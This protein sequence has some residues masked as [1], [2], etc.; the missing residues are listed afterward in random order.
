MI[1][2]RAYLISIVAIFL[3]LGIGV[4]AGATFIDQLTVDALNQ[5]IDRVEKNLIEREEEQRRLEARIEE[6]DAFTAEA[7]NQLVTDVLVGVPVIV[8]AERGV[9]SATVDSTVEL[10]EAAGASVGGVL[11][12]EEGVLF[13]DPALREEVADAL[14]STSDDPGEL[15]ASTF[16]AIGRSLTNGDEVSLSSDGTPTTLAPESTTTATGA[17]GQVLT[18]LLDSGVVSWEP[19][20]EGQSLAEV[21]DPSMRV[22]VVAGSESPLGPSVTIQL[23]RS[24]TGSG[25][26]VVVAEVTPTDGERGVVVGPIRN[27]DDLTSQVSTVDDLELASGRVAA[28]LAVAGLGQGTVGHYGFAD[29]ATSV[30]PPPQPS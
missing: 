11:W 28:V 19:S 22:L 21:A 27:D 5:S 13:E 30:L 15:Q 25:V 16:R 8:V 7:S 18:A 23:A 6:S 1:T 14:G 2:V 9:E 20:E 3:A 12:I 26:P 17:I 10:A 29:G 24:L 4:V